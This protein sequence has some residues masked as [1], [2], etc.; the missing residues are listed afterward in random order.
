MVSDDAKFSPHSLASGNSP[1]LTSGS[2]FCSANFVGLLIIK[3]DKKIL[4][5]LGIRVCI[6]DDL[7]HCFH[8]CLQKGFHCS[9]NEFTDNVGEVIISIYMYI[10]VWLA[11]GI[12]D[13]RFSCWDHS[14][15]IAHCFTAIVT[16]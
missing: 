1:R 4:S 10:D 7:F 16:F 8:S 3:N 13:Y 14:L 15:I 11:F 2:A 5:P 9:T 6:T 12:L